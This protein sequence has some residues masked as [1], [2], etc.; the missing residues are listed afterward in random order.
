MNKEQLLGIVRHALTF[1]GG[2]LVIKGIATEA[3][4][5][6]VIGTVMT[7]IGAVWSYIKNGTAA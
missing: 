7:A 6:E 5:N 4:T 2:I 3:V 1:I